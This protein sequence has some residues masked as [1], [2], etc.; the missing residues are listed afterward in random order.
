M[1]DA[2]TKA[3]WA[4]EEEKVLFVERCRGNDQGLHNPKLKW[5]QVKEAF[6]RDPYCWNIFLLNV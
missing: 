2:P 1:P 5:N 6:L 3:R 4:T